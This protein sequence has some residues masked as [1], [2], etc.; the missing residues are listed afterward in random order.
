M[1]SYK[2]EKEISEKKRKKKTETDREKKRKRGWV[3][4]IEKEGSGRRTS[5]S[6]T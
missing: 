3:R 2:R 6:K 4:A 1:E 5:Q